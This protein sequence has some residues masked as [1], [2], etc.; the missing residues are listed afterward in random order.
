[1]SIFVCGA[2]GI[3]GS[4]LVN[5]LDSQ[6]VLYFGTYN[7]NKIKNGIKIDFFN[8]N[9][10]KKIMITNNVFICINCVVERQLDI[11]E[12]NWAKIKKTNID[13]TNNLSKVC[14]L[15][16]VHLIHISTDY[17]FD[18]KNAPY[19]PCN[20]P[21][22]LQ[23]Y[24]IS[25]LISEYKVLANCKK[26]TIIRVPV[27]YTNNIR[28]LEDSAVTLI[29]KKILNRTE[30]FKE[31][32]FSIRR[33]NYIPDFCFFIYDFIK[34]PKIG[35][36]HFCNPYDKVTKFE[37][38][39]II[40][41]ILHKKINVIPINEEPKDG[42]ERPKD[43]FLKDEK[44]NIFNYKFTELKKGLEL[45]FTKLSHPKL[46]I[47]SNINT[48]NIFF[49]IDL[50]GTLID[51]EK[52]HFNAY[53]DI[54]KSMYEY[55]LDYDK[56]N[57]ILNEQGIDNFL[58]NSFGVE[59]KNKI[60]ELKNKNFQKNEK[61]NIIKNADV[62]IDFLDKYDI[63]HVVVTNTSLDNVNFLKSKVSCLNKIKNWMTRENYIYQKP[64]SECYELAKKL[65]YKNEGCVIGIENTLVGY[66]SI[67]KITECLY[68][69]T[70][71][72][73]YDYNEL[74][75]QDVYLIDDFLEI[76]S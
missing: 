72:H 55:N 36:Y 7:N 57:I 42:V 73:H 70:N 20:Q 11:C 15:L 63:N 68:M 21:N 66:N 17:V 46:E 61:I 16:D 47:N 52:L 76:F 67:K 58:I 8:L 43:T 24:G 26:Y 6:N 56:Y 31:D 33:P 64:H 34:T 25:K 4:E 75:K 18:G 12:G 10:I 39:S 49:L 50:D 44:Y 45:C 48:K 2:S 51:T 22:P 53:Q 69:V 29:G 71:K 54:L 1:M 62:F 9:E 19:L 40:S 30:F 41:E 27:L 65:Y 13:I 74:L 60:K 38:A 32:N 5:L 3:L 35:T 59:E 28:N 23:N 37:I 14:N